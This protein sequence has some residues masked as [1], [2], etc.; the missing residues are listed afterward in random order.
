M[1]AVPIPTSPIRALLPNTCTTIRLKDNAAKK[2][3]ASR[4]LYLRLLLFSLGQRTGEHLHVCARQPSSQQPD[5][6]D[7]QRPSTQAQ[8][9]YGRSILVAPPSSRNTGSLLLILL[10][11]SRWPKKY[12]LRRS[13][14]SA[15]AGLSLSIKKTQHLVA[16]APNPLSLAKRSELPYIFDFPKHPTKTST[17]LNNHLPSGT[18]PE[19]IYDP[20]AATGLARRHRRIH[21]AAPN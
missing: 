9:N 1:L 5:A 20:A 12:V 4:A 13:V 8:C 11:I 21:R 7:I 6:L 14:P 10:I 16:S 15:T 2:L 18:P 17:T 3:R 19:Y